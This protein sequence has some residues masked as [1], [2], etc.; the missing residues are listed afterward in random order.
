MAAE[1]FPVAP[2]RPLQ[3]PKRVPLYPDG[4]IV[5][6]DRTEPLGVG[7]E[8]QDQPLGIECSIP[9]GP[10]RTKGRA[11]PGPAPPNLV[12]IQPLDRVALPLLP[13]YLRPQLGR[14]DLGAGHPG[15]ALLPQAQIHAGCLVESGRQRL[16]V[17]PTGQAQGEQWVA[18]VRLDLGS[19]Q[20]TGCPPRLPVLATGFQDEDG[21][22]GGGQLPGT[23]GPSRPASDHDYVVCRSHRGG[24]KLFETSGRTAA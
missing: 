10:Q 9:R 14:I 21:T 4:P 11:Q 2:T 3:R 12:R 8:R 20:A 7:Q 5:D 24:M 23:R 15:Y 13:R 22:A 18:R 1:D 6:H 19:K 16:V 17:V